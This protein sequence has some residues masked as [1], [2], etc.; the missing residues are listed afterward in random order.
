MRVLLTGATGFIGRHCLEA[1][2]DDDAEVHAVS[3]KGQ[4]AP[5]SGVDW[6]SVD[7]LDPDEVSQLMAR[8]QPTHLIHCAWYMEPGSVYTSPTNYRWVHASLNLLERFVLEGGQRA[9]MAGTCAEYDWRY[10]YFSEGITPLSPHTVYGACKHALQIMFD[11]LIRDSGLSG[12]WARIFFV[13]GPHE[14]PAR[15]VSSVVGS[16][17]RGE[18]A[19]CSHGKQVRDYLHVNDAAMAMTAL[20]KSDVEG[21]VNIASGR[22]VAI[23]DIISTIARQLGGEHLI[24]LGALP[25]AEN[26]PP[27]IVADTGRLAKEVGWRPRY[28]LNEGLEQTIRWWKN[29]FKIGEVESL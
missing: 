20:L 4:T 14:H 7:L 22:P 29:E 28:D 9:V 8:V 23:R 6:H 5:G 26:E 3:F 10:G 27:L 2:R 18:K 11:A 25:T 24:Q 1:L 21:P 16:V 15:L 17:L 13:Y 12:A 19:R